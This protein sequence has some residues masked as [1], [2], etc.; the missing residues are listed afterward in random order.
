MAGANADDY[1]KLI[2]QL[3]REDKLTN[4]LPLFK[5]DPSL[6]GLMWWNK[7]RI[8]KDGNDTMDVLHASNALPNCDYFFTEKE[9]R[10]MIVKL[11]LDKSFGGVV[12]SD[13][14]KVLEA[15]NAI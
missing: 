7:D 4:E 1:C 12:E 15:L 9:L 5:I 11:K 2:I 14:K 3:F 10:S 8:Y 13:G 6:F